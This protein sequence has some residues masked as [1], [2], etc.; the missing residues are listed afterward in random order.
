M[1]KKAWRPRFSALISVSVGV[2]LLTLLVV[3]QGFH[4]RNH[5]IGLQIELIQAN[6]PAFILNAEKIVKELPKEYEKEKAQVFKQLH[7][8]KMLRLEEILKNKKVAK[9]TGLAVDV[10]HQS[11]HDL[12]QKMS[13]QKFLEKKQKSEIK[14]WL[15]FFKSFQES[16]YQFENLS[17]LIKDR[18]D[19]IRYGASKFINLIFLSQ[20]PYPEFKL[21]SQLTDFKVP[22]K[23]DMEDLET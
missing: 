17:Y 16:Y 12:F 2:V 18:N 11:F 1:K 5:A 9:E 6:Y 20:R 22:A 10:M 8:T 3:I 21:S 23:F 13:E 4:N 7:H 14:K 15:I 19:H